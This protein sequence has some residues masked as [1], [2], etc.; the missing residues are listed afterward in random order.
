[1]GFR[2]REPAVAQD[3]HM[4]VKL[5]FEDQEDTTTTL[6]PTQQP[7]P[8]PPPPSR[9]VAWQPQQAGWSLQLCRALPVALPP[10][11]GAR[12]SGSRWQGVVGRMLP[13]ADANHD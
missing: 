2:V 5:K 11:L 10:A 8:P 7:T 4:V 1:M 9:T 6:P 12:A 13:K 3:Q